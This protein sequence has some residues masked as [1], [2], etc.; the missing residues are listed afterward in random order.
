MSH[1]SSVLVVV[2]AVVEVVA[3]VFLEVVVVIVV[4]AEKRGALL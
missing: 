3:R 1:S 2:G 4:Q